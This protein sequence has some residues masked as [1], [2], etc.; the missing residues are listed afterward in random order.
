M[1]YCYI[2]TLDWKKETPSSELLKDISNYFSKRNVRHE[3]NTN[4]DL[5]LK[6]ESYS[7]ILTIGESRHFGNTIRIVT[8][9]KTHIQSISHGF[10]KLVWDV[11]T[12]DMNVSYKD[13][14]LFEEGNF[15]TIDERYNERL[16][17]RKSM[18]EFLENQSI[19]ELP[20]QFDFKQ[21]NNIKLTRGLLISE[22]SIPFELVW[23]SF[24]L[25]LGY[26]EWDMTSAEFI[27]LR[28]EEYEKEIV[29]FTHHWEELNN[30]NYDLLSDETLISLI[31]ISKGW[32]YNE[33]LVKYKNK[34]QYI[35]ADIYTG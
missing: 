9:C 15:K 22:K 24:S 25:Q 13:I 28:L 27:P 34:Y 32:D 30:T 16:I 23:Y 14:E 19:Q 18:C 7:F 11:L 1:E 35:G 3:E 5:L 4:S 31:R 12:Q 29:E 20:I 6:Y 26:D 8:D 17:S 33:Y 10:I 21:T 2:I